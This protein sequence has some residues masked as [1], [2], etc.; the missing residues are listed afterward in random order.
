MPSSTLSQEVTQLLRQVRG[1]NDAGKNRLFD[2]VHEQLKRIAIRY[3]KNEKPG[4]TL[5]PTALVNEA[6]LRL[7]GSIEAIPWEDRAH[8]YGVA[9]RQMRRI[10]VDHSRK[11]KAGKRGG[12]GVHLTLSHAEGIQAGQDFDGLESALQELEQK[13]PDVGQ[14]IELRFFAGMEDKEV[15][16]ALGISFAKVRRAWEFGKAFLYHRLKT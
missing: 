2:V 1:G 4:H 8:F 14:V 15:A 10:L 9:A 12:A 7:F 16:E 5:Q 11:K 6:Y 3:M 13:A